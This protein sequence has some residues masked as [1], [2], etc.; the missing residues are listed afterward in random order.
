MIRVLHIISPGTGSFGGIEAFLY[1]YYKHMDRNNVLFDF[2]FCAKNTM[3]LKQQDLVF[4]SSRFIEMECI[5]RENN[6]I[7]DW[8]KLRKTIRSIAKEGKYDYIE[9]HT[10][11][12]LIQ[13]VSAI[14]LIGIK[15]IKIAHSHAM[16]GSGKDWKY[17]LINRVCAGVITRRNR[18][19]FSCSYAAGAVFGKRGVRSSKFRKIN[20]AVEA[21]KYRFDPAIRNKVRRNNNI[22]EDCLVVGHVARLAKEKNQPFLVDVFRKIHDQIPQSVLWIVGGGTYKEE[23]ENRIKYNKIENSVFLMGERRDVSELLQGMDVFIVPSI[24]EGL[25]IS[26]VESQAAGLPTYVSTGI[27]DECRITDQI[28][29]LSL[30]DSA[31]EWANYIVSDLQKK[32]RADCY[33]RV[34]A[35]GYDIASCANELQ[36]FYMNHCDKGRTKCRKQ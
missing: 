8:N 21:E 4:K 3:K 19:L 25:C 9:T 2:A 5:S 15:G 17:K 11:A 20:N 28:E 26:A 22:H 32:Q 13:A 30:D 18:Y 6:S 27:P 29:Y 1:E 7:D 12:P 10:S 33:D 16:T 34:V 24:K 23:I 36:E 35:S 14:A 31:E